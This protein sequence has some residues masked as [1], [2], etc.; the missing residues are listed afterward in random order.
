MSEPELQLISIAGNV[1]T[2]DTFL[3]IGESSDGILKNTDPEY[4]P[5]PRNDGG[6]IDIVNNFSWYTGPKAEINA[7]NKVPRAFIVERRQVLNS[8]ISGALYYLNTIAA[9]GKKLFSS[10]GNTSNNINGDDK[11]ISKLESYLQKINGGVSSKI[12][13]ATANL[14]FNTGEDEAILKAHNLESLIGIYLTKKTGFNYTFPYFGNTPEI[15][16][17]W[18]TGGEGAIAGLVNSGMQV[19]DEIS[20]ITNIAQPGVYIEK[21]KY[22]NFAEEGKSVTISFPLFNTIRRSTF[23]PYQQNYELLWLLAFQNRPY[24]T[25]FARTP[26]PKIYTVTIPGVYSTPYS[27]ISN[28]SIDFK[29]TTRQLKVA[30]PTLVNGGILRKA[31]T[32][33]PIPEAYVVNVTFTS[34]LNDYANQMIGSNYTTTIEGFK[35]SV[36][37]S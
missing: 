13:N 19:I 33:V 22:F 25:S 4:R 17:S 37:T 24:K 29:G 6:A 12:K 15:T 18:S 5:E 36:G 20:K 9:T 21:P 10:G 34:L 35:A 23:S 28:L 31:E 14:K 27:Y 1:E 3:G 2:T 32:K 30:T 16:S 8:L 26:P 11:A 7:L